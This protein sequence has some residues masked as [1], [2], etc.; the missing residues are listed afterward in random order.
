MQLIAH[1]NQLDALPPSPL[2][3][4]I[5]ARRQSLIETDDDI[6]PIFII[7]EEDDDIT[8]PDYAFVGN[9]GLLSDLFE[10][11]EPKH[12]EFASPYEWAS[13]LLELEIYEV[14]LLTHG[15]DGALIYVPESLVEAHPDLK[16]VLTSDEQE[17]FS[18]PQPLQ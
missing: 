5:I 12:P 6:P 11:H 13:Y 2:K 1:R 17:E 3:N 15:E 4:H 16:W 18:D 7:V 14:L 8:G 10:E 9:R